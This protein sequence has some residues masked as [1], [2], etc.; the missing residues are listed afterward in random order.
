MSQNCDIGGVHCDCC[1]PY[2]GKNKPLLNRK[3]R[4]M[5]KE[6]TNREVKQ[7]ETQPEEDV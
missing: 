5:L 6:Q 3:A 2:H 4:R 1:N 7:E